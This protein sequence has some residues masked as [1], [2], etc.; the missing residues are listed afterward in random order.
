MHLRGERK[1]LA[2]FLIKERAHAEAASVAEDLVR[3]SGADSPDIPA[4]AATYWTVCTALA[5]QDDTLPPERRE[6]AARSYAHRAR[7]V[8]RRLVD[9]GNDE[10]AVANLCWF[11]VV[12]P[13]PELREPARSV[14]LARQLIEES[15]ND[16]KP[17]F[18][19]G[20]A[21]CRTGDWQGA[22]DALKKGGDLNGGEFEFW[23]FVRAVAHW[24]LDHKDL[25]RES[26]H[27]A[28]SWLAANR[29]EADV[30]LLRT[31]AAAVLGLL[32]RGPPVTE[33]QTLETKID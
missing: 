7:D 32:E 21:L 9:A 17:E 22:L 15:P 1:T 28:E 33:R 14:Q 5:W 26:F 27:C 30:R 31:E 20:A 3:D 23:G 4:I 25:A 24:R 11:L 18:L 29:A 10:N 13:A 12:C 16:P 8:L 2:S 6:A 19:L